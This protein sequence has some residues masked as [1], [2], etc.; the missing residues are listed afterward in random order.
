MNIPAL[1]LFNEA[2]NSTSIDLNSAVMDIIINL[3]YT[4]NM[5]VEDAE[6][7]HKNHPHSESKA[8]QINFYTNVIIKTTS[9]AKFN[10]DEVLILIS[11]IKIGSFQ[12][13]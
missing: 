2:S 5:I 13:H 3:S 10:M 1:L 6:D 8:P 9:I 7:Q 12:V 4:Y 11:L